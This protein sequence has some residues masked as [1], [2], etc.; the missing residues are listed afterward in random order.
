V[1]AG[2][3]AGVEA[4]GVVDGARS[5]VTGGR[6]GEQAPDHDQD[7]AGYRDQGPELAAPFDQPPVSSAQERI[8]LAGRRGGVAEN[9]LG[10]GWL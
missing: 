2:A 5:W 7:S 4:A 3:A 9:A 6:V 10:R 8:G 1:V